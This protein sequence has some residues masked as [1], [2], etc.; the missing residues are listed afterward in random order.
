MHRW[1]D[2]YSW[3][4]ASGEAMDP[5]ESCGC[6]SRHP[7]PDSR[8]SRGLR[9]GV[10]ASVGSPAGYSAESSSAGHRQ[11]AALP[12]SWRLGGWP[13]PTNPPTPPSRRSASVTRPGL[14]LFGGG[15]SYSLA[16]RAAGVVRGHRR[17][18]PSF[19]GAPPYHHLRSPR[20]PREGKLLF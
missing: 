9:W 15:G 4:Y 16:G 10:M 12:R 13:S 2:P 18:F 7:F 3:E 1:L 14:P 11:G 8:T 17:E 20:P 19:P 6:L 5:W